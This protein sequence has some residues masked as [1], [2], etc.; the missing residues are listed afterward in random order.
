MDYKKYVVYIFAALLAVLG[1]VFLVFGGHT[2]LGL[3][4]T[5]LAGIAAIVAYFKWDKILVQKAI[6]VFLFF[7]IMFSKK[8]ETKDVLKKSKASGTKSAVQIPN[9]IVTPKPAWLQFG[10][11]VNWSFN[12]HKNVILVFIAFFIVLMQMTYFTGNVFVTVF[13]LIMALLLGLAFFLTKQPHYHVEINAKFKEVA[14]VVLGFAVLALA[15]VLMLINSR[16]AFFKISFGNFGTQQVAFWLTIVGAFI[17]LWFLPKPK[18]EEAG[19]ENI[20]IRYNWVKNKMI[21]VS[22]VGAAVLFYLLG[23]V[24][25][26]GNEVL[27]IVSYSLFFVCLMLS[28]PWVEKQIVSIKNERADFV[29]RSIVI[30]VGMLLAYIGQKYFYLNKVNMAMIY[31]VASA[32]LFIN[33][34][35]PPLNL[36]E[37]N[38][39]EK[40]TLKTEMIIL[41]LITAFGLFLRL[42]EINIRPVGIEN[43]E[44]GGLITIFTKF[45]NLMTFRLGRYSIYFHI[46]EPI[47][48]ALGV[49]HLSIKLL[50]IIIG[51]LTIPAMYFA[52]RYMFNSWAAII[53]TIM[54]AAARWH[55]HFSRSGHG[56]IMLPLTMALMIYFFIRA[57][58][59]RDKWTFFVS[60]L[61]GGLCWHGYASGKL[62]TF[63]LMIFLM[64]KIF[65]EKLFLRKFILGIMAFSVG[66]WIFASPI[67]QLW[68]TGRELI[69]GRSAD[70]SV[71][72]KDPNAPKNAALG[73]YENAKKVFLMFND[74]GDSRQRNTGMQP[75]DKTIDFWS[76]LFFMLGLLYSLYYWRDNRFLVFILMFLSISAASIFSIEAPSG[77]RVF[78]AIPI[79][80]FYA[81]IP[82]YIIT[83]F[84]L[85]KMNKKSA[86]IVIILVLGPILGATVKENYNFYFNRWVGGVDELATRAG[87]F[88]GH[89]GK[90]Y[91]TVLLGG[92]YYTGHPPYKI[93]TWNYTDG[94]TANFL[95]C[96]PERRVTEKYKGFIYIVHNAYSGV[97]P[98][99]QKVYPNGKLETDSHPAFG[100]FFDAYVVPAEDIMKTRGL[101]ATYLDNTGKKIILD[102]N[103]I[104]FSNTVSAPCKVR[105]EGLLY[106]PSYGR[107]TIT[108][109][110]SNNSA[111]LYIDGEEVIRG[112]KN[113]VTREFVKGLHEITVV[114]DKQNNNDFV[115]AFIKTYRSQDELSVLL[116]EQ[117]IPDNMFY[118]NLPVNG[119]EGIYYSNVM[120]SGTV[121]LKEL[122]PFVMADQTIANPPYAVTWEG[123]LKIDV[124]NTYSFN[125]DTNAS[126]GRI[127]LNNKD[128]YV[129]GEFPA[130]MSKQVPLKQIKLLKGYY[131]I[132]IYA[133]APGY[134]NLKWT[135]D[136][137]NEVIQAE[138]LFPRGK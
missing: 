129:R 31:F 93:F 113:S 75:Y 99:L 119:L 1:Q 71:F 68:F 5:I 79:V 32:L 18:P 125:L 81:A 92:G 41:L 88:A 115:R 7:K 45:D 76:G 52:I 51:T 14:G 59:H 135:H 19:Q 2:V 29:V 87:E 54:F 82:I 67:F 121:Q 39:K 105:L 33:F 110:S 23:G 94:N 65:S 3:S 62:V 108:L 36:H 25:S 104:A 101:K 138:Y 8:K 134:I 46:M 95:D 12:I 78:G 20:D 24:A 114:A 55:L 56:T 38:E 98:Y 91:V 127:V 49:T 85:S 96:F 80:F 34:F 84:I 112:A 17:V 133:S 117:L 40:F 48:K 9:S 118:K 116:A 15:W 44:A 26:K 130:G 131:P 42:Y 66:F 102:Q 89:Y 6:E 83:S 77:F 47:I 60:G 100:K 128:V 10:T 111:V 86:A 27:M 74:Q 21:K 43:D 107:T 90:D 97:V 124:E 28:L 64:Y 70:V 58:K 109:A 73:I 63:G 106:I 13:S 30:V 103:N 22:L 123:F 69:I 57:L 132:K 37:Q 16:I 35:P 50:G 137:I 61:A 11:D 72:S 120:F 126:F 53:V 4:L 136:S 122:D